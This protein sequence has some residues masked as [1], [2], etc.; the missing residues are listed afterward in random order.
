MTTNALLKP[1]VFDP[2]VP[3]SPPPSQAPSKGKGKKKEPTWIKLIE[4]DEWE[5]RGVYTKKK[6]KQRTKKR[7]EAAT[8]NPSPRLSSEIQVSGRISESDTAVKEDFE[9]ATQEELSRRLAEPTVGSA[10]R[11]DAATAENQ[12]PPLQIISARR[13]CLYFSILRVCYL[14]CMGKCRFCSPLVQW[15]PALFLE[16]L[17]MM[18]W[19]T[20]EILIK[21]VQVGPR[22]NCISQVMFISLVPLLGQLL[23]HVN[24]WTF[25]SPPKQKQQPQQRPP[26]NHGGTGSQTQCCLGGIMSSFETPMHAANAA[27]EIIRRTRGVVDGVLITVT[28]RNPDSNPEKYDLVKVCNAPYPFCNHWCYNCLKYFYNSNM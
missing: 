12:F 13:V 11:S 7:Q 20:N 17:S 5:R 3:S 4:E 10:D 23:G 6:R 8:Y 25:T 21:V 22:P 18:K 2:H 27:V 1:A 9:R 19:V 28:P 16:A 15:H 26:S 24:S 14:A